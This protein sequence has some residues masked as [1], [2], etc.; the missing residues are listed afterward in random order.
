MRQAWHSMIGRA[1][2][3]SS[4]PDMRVSDRLLSRPSLGAV[5]Y[6][7]GRATEMRGCQSEVLAIA[8][9]PR[10]VVGSMGNEGPR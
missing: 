4:W 9:I 1:T 8:A 7:L 2:C 6:A 3:A 10:A 5:A